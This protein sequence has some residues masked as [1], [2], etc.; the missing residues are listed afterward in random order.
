M[1]TIREEFFDK[2]T[3][4]AKWDVGVSINRTNG[5]PL[6]VYSVFKSTEDLNNYVSGVFS[7]PGQVLALVKENET[8]IYYLDQNKAL[9]EV[10]SVPV[11]DGKTIEVVDGKI[12]L[13][14]SDTQIIPEGA[15][16]AVINTGAVLTLQADGS[17]KWV[18]PDTSTA[19]GQAQAIADLQGRTT[20]LEAEVASL[21]SAFDFKGTATSISEDLKYIYNNGEPIE[22]V[23]TGDVYQIGDKEY[24][25]NGEVFVEL[26]F[27]VDL[28]GYAT[29]TY[30]DQ[31]E[32]DAV[33]A[34][35]GTDEDTAESNTIK[36]AKKF[37]EAKTTAAETAAKEYTD[38][39]IEKLNISQYATTE[40]LNG[41]KATAEAA[42]TQTSVDTLTGIVNSHTTSIEGINGS[43]N[44]ISGRVGSLETDNTTNKANIKTN[45]DN[46]AT[47]NELAN[48][49]KTGLATLSGTVGQHTTDIGKNASDLAA[50]TTRVGTAEGKI[51][52]VETSLENAN[53][54]IG[55]KAN[56]ADV[57]TK[58]E[59]GDLGG[60]TVITLIDEAKTAATYDDTAIKALIQG[61]TDAI[62]QAKQDALDAVSALE[63]GAVATNAENIKKNTDAIAVLNGDDKVE[64]SVDYKVAQEVA[65]ILND[66]DESDI[67]TLEEIAAWIKN[68]TAGV[69]D[70]NRRI[71]VNEG[72]ITIINST[73]IPAAIQTA[74]DYTDAQITALDLAN[75]YE[76]K[77]AAET[78]LAAAKSYTDTSLS[79]YKAKEVVS[80]HDA[81]VVETDENGKVT[82]GF[83]SEIILNGGS[84]N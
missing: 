2:L 65:K 81:L 26:G 56:S 76:A 10:G 29:E 61:N 68:D 14:A 21:G 70:L 74:K 3:S 51:T 46:I 23:S 84:A 15:E 25:Y 45:T 12:Q 75:T 77:G 64:G 66:N 73:T 44:T 50:L 80:G 1:A 19:E 34:A 62:A 72:A 6:D 13:K 20:A 53:T 54:E 39:E 43:I 79:G 48:E 40:A 17:L 78:A 22:N 37:A 49:N 38:D 58:T 28:T 52:A 4:G 16:E 83:A 11:G 69:A 67:D 27:N 42:A 71:T 31:A 33:A 7:Y 41:V 57:Y 82:I 24:A 8:V 47:L 36:G 63:T 59:I 32:S 60:K 35:V 9:K 5:V 18:K 55:K 30:V